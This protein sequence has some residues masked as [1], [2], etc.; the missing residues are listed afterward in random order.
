[1]FINASL[2]VQVKFKRSFLRS[3]LRR[4]IPPSSVSGTMAS[5]K[6]VSPSRGARHSPKLVAAVHHSRHLPITLQKI[7][8]FPAPEIYVPATECPNGSGQIIHRDVT[9]RRQHTQNDAQSLRVKFLRK[10]YA[11]SSNG[12]FY[13]LE[14][15]V[16]G[17]ISFLYHLDSF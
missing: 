11:Y 12:K 3:P 15:H 2:S 17:Y 16:F 10:C 4:R 5:V 9:A 6:S 1:M 14:S 13:A 8:L 7:T